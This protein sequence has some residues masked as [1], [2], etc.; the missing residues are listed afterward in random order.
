[1]YCPRALLPTLVASFFLAGT[2][3]AQMGGRGMMQQPPPMVGAF[4]PTV[5]AGSQYQMTAKDRNMQFAM[6]IVGRETVG[7]AEGYWIEQRFEGGGM[8][9][10]MVQ[11]QLLVIQG[12]K[13]EI[14]RMIMQPPG[15]GPME[16]PVAMMRSGMQQATGTKDTDTGERVG[17][18]SVT[19]PAGTFECE[20]YRKQTDQGTFDYWISPKVSPYPMVKVT[21]PDMTMVLEKLLSGETSHIHGEPQQMPAMPGMP[22]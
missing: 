9:G 14:K 10:E 2:I 6:V 8:P 18:E 7:G 17:T 1:M 15:R 20:H 4:N 5:G 19:V 22:H 21:G 16:M 13:P 12:G 11:K 3:E